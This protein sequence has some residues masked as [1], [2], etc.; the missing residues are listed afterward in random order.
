[1]FNLKT[2]WRCYALI[3]NFSTTI[4]AKPIQVN[5][6][7]V[8]AEKYNVLR[9]DHKRRDFIISSMK[10]SEIFPKKRNMYF[11]ANYPSLT[12]DKVNKGEEYTLDQRDNQ[13]VIVSLDPLELNQVRKKNT[14]FELSFCFRFSFLHSCSIQDISIL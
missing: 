8:L 14:I 13:N 3:R 1:M 11:I 2:K 10:I 9:Y 6:N 5:L 7:E 4:E 12:L